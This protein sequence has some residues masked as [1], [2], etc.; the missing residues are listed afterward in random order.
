MLTRREVL[1]KTALATGYAL[2][3]SVASG[4]L[5]GC[6]ADSTPDW[7]PSAFSFEQSQLVV[8]LANTILPTTANSPGAKDVGV[9]QFMDAVI[10]DCFTPKDKATFLAGVDAFE[11][12]CKSVMGESFVA[13][14]P[15]KQ[16]DFVDQQDK[17]GKAALTQALPP[18]PEGEKPHDRR[19]FF[20]RFKELT[21]AGYFTAEQVGKEVLEYLSI[22]GQFKPCIPVEEVGR[23]WAI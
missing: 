3:A 1:K 16:L 17:A 23:A 20:I 19:P 5:S 14:S 11:T 15:E 2:S 18:L 4:I 21:I 6:T 7:T 10:A 9:H 22:P 12:S 8:D 13:L